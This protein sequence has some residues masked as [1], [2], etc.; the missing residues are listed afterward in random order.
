MVQ[1]YTSPA[2]RWSSFWGELSRFAV[3]HY[4][5]AIKFVL[6]AICLLLLLPPAVGCGRKGPQPVPVEGT[7]TFGG[8]SWPKPGTL[9]FTLDM[10]GTDMPACPATAI[11][12][13]D[14]KVTVTT[15]KTGDGL[16]PGKYKVTVQCWQVA[17]QPENPMAAR[18]YV[19]ARYQNAATSDL[20][21]NITSG[22]SGADFKLD[23]P[24]R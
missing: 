1:Q 12:D 9:R 7:I 21:V 5:R 24:K 18:S 17:P 8:G 6:P 3:M 16:I 15:F 19:P 20:A 11:F 4:R 2:N 23:V 22:Q 10:A 13:T 14:G